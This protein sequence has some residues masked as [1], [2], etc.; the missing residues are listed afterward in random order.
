VH[1]EGELV[2]VI[3]KETRYVTESEASDA[4]FGVTVGND[5]TERGWQGRDLQWLRSK[6][7]DGFG[8]I[9]ATITRGMDYNNVIL[10]TRLNG[11]VVQQEST[12]N[13]IH[14]P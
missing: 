8:P 6:A 3:G 14:S 7:A 13:M 5:I 1:F 4:I 12:K 9:G 2:L 11:K 10:T